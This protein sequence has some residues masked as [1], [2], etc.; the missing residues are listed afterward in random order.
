MKIV[1]VCAFYGP[2]SGGVRTYVDRKL[3][4]AQAHGHEVVVIAP[5]EC[6]GV[7]TRTFGGRVRWLRAPR[8]PLEGSAFWASSAEL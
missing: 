5:G 6:D 3:E 4:A 2:R 7:E 8:F 1:D